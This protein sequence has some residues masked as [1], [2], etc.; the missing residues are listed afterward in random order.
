MLCAEIRRKWI[1]FF[2]S[3]T[4]SLDAASKPMPHRLVQSSSLVPDNPT[5]LLTAAGMLQFVPIFMG[6]APVPEPPRAVTIQKCVRVGGK[7]SDLNNIGRTTRHHS[8]FEM[9]GNFSFGDYFKSEAISWAWQF[10]TQELKLPASRLFVSVFA[11]DES[12]PFDKDAYDIWLKLLQDYSKQHQIDLETTFDG[13][14]AD[15][16]GSKALEKRIWHLGRKDNFWG[17]PGISGPCGPCSEIYY[18]LGPDYMTYGH[19]ERFIEIWNLVFMEFEKTETG[20]Y[21]PLLRRNID[22]GAGLERIATILQGV[23]NSFETDELFRILNALAQAFNISYKGLKASSDLERKQDL[24]LKIIADHLRCLCFLIADGVRPS[25]LGRAYV[26][27]MIIRRASRFA[28]ILSDKAQAQLYQYTDVVVESYGQAYPELLAAKDLIR[29]ICYKE[30]EQFSK[31]IKKG[32]EIL[33]AFIKENKSSTLS[34]DFVFDLYST[35]GFPLEI[36]EEIA[37]EAGLKID[38]ESYEAAKTR[39]SEASNTGAFSVAAIDKAGL[40]SGLGLPATQFLG[41]ELERSQVRILGILDPDSQACSW[42][43]PE[44]TKAPDTGEYRS[45]QLILDKTPFYAESGGQEGDKGQLIGETASIDVE[46]TKKFQDLFLHKV[47]FANAPSFRLSVGDEF[48]ACVDPESRRL[49]RYHHSA[50]HLLQA[51]LRKLLGPNIQQA[52]SQV[53]PQYTRFDFNFERALTSQEIEIL[54]TQI[55]AWIQADYPV[56]TRLMPYDEALASGALAFFEDKYDRDTQVRVLM[57]GDVSVELCGGT[58]VSRTSEIDYIKIV[59][60]SSVA[61]GIRRIKLLASDVAGRYLQEEQRK[62][63]EK[64]KLAELKLKEAEALKARQQE[65]LTTLALKIPVL[66]SQAIDK[67]DHKVLIFQ[68]NDFI[69]ADDLDADSIK[70]FAERL[71]SSFQGDVLIFLSYVFSETKLLFMALASDNLTDRYNC[72]TLVKTAAQICS[73]N[74]GGKANFAQAGAK[75]ASKLKQALEAIK[76]ALKNEVLRGH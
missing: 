37:A 32:L 54:E 60:E 28:L 35:Y 17:P 65:L 41:Y 44:Q 3:K 23:N 22:T 46:D 4:V 15:G 70:S 64:I 30:E 67:E 27:R 12:N 66:Q 18:D 10:L 73:G 39:H 38:L 25:N 34:G 47:N 33:E 14:N 20:D 72:S 2:T 68:L 16:S 40:Y 11:G 61:A 42:I 49:T 56:E 1:E 8:F 58:H 75:D 57:M 48:L 9:L 19:D 53:G 43:S 51:A 52:G 71:R 6:A 50:C 7:D 63:A 24:Y 36:T 55:N 76:D 26:L 74:G 21:Q 69:Q 29:E 59:S 5:L 62:A 13:P 31:T 45:F